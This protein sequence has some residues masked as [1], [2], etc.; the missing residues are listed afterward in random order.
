MR[1]VPPRK[2]RSM[3]SFRY[4]T[5]NGPFSIV[6]LADA[7][8]SCNRQPDI[9]GDARWRT[10]PTHLTVPRDFH[11]SGRPLDVR[12]CFEEALAQ[13][14]KSVANGANP[15]CDTYFLEL[16]KARAP[17]M[18]RSL[19]DLLGYRLI[20]YR[21]G[22]TSAADDFGGTGGARS[23]VL[24]EV[25]WSNNVN[26][27]AIISISAYAA[28]SPTSLAATLIHELA[29]VAGAPGRPGD[30]DWAG[31]GAAARAPYFGAENALRAC[32]F[33]KQH[34]PAIYGEIQDRFRRR[35]G[36]TGLA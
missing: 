10:W 17:D 18:R 19:T 35:M 29:H 20:F 21:H 11:G 5:K 14:H 8:A 25:L 16:G 24:G 22:A 28:R 30:A 23:V 33:A 3:A 36:L 13:V 32:G 26:R 34:N 12:L 4:I 6:G 15:L 9:P 7:G 27:H 31:M 1:R 2:T